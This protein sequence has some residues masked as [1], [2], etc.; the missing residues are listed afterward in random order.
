MT[1]FELL[2]SSGTAA[3]KRKQIITYKADGE[4]TKVIYKPL[5]DLQRLYNDVSIIDMYADVM[6]GRVDIYRDFKPCLNITTI[7]NDIEA[8]KLQT[9]L[10]NYCRSIASYNNFCTIIENNISNNQFI[11]ND[12]LKLLEIHRDNELLQ[13][14]K[15]AKSKFLQAKEE[16]Y[17][18]EARQKEEECKVEQE[19]KKAA[20][21]KLVAEYE[22]K[23]VNKEAFRNTM[24]ETPEGKETSII[25][26]L[27]Q[28]YDIQVP[29]KTQGW[30][31]NG[32]AK[33]A[34]NK[35]EGKEDITYF[36]YNRNSKVF[37]DY[38]KSLEFAILDAYGKITDEERTRA[39][40]AE[41][42]AEKEK[43]LYNSIA[44]ID[45]GKMTEYRDEYELHVMIRQSEPL[46]ISISDAEEI[47]KRLYKAVGVKNFDEIQ[48]K[49]NSR[50]ASYTE[51]S[52]I[53][54]EDYS[55]GTKC[56]CRALKDKSG[57]CTYL[58]KKSNSKGNYKALEHV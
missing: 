30:I 31:K 43:I 7:Y 15:Q 3:E 57:R 51:G 4:G 33:V 42:E 26:Y 39:T 44:N 48:Y 23:I 19:A 56:S 36:Y 17:K 28:K 8:G 47:Y 52:V 6:D 21:E 24:I 53:S 13:K 58:F 35:T 55:N 37:Y 45:F 46:T 2:K 29:L 27:C 54:V 34:W 22:Q 41:Q 20:F 32:L 25:L 11:K 14:A 10:V 1:F 9:A 16:E 38:L 40:E 5:I 50:M 12:V 49:V 18:Q